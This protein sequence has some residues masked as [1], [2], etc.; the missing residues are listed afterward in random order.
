M[1]RLEARVILIYVL[2]SRPVHSHTARPSSQ[3]MMI[4]KIITLGYNKD[5]I[6]YDICMK[7]NA[8][9]YTD[10]SVSINFTFN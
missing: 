4:T 8:N 5:R 10:K 9:M 1:L 3:V 7:E 6:E 2:Y